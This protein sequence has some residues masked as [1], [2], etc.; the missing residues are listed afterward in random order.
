MVATAGDVFDQPKV[1]DGRV[2]VAAGRFSERT[3]IRLA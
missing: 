1:A 3:R 2:R